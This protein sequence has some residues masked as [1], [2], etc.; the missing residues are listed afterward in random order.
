MTYA[1]ETQPAPDHGGGHPSFVP[2]AIERLTDAAIAARDHAFHG[3]GHAVEQIADALGEH[4][5]LRP[6]AAD[7]IAAALLGRT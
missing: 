7:A 4:G 3:L 5:G 1:T 6:E 2:E